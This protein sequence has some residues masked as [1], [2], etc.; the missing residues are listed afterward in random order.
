MEVAPS[1]PDHLNKHPVVF[2]PGLR[3][4]RR[5]SLKL[6][7]KSEQTLTRRLII[8]DVTWE[9]GAHGG[10][11]T[12]LQLV[13]DAEAGTQLQ[14]HQGPAR[15]QQ[16]EVQA[17]GHDAQ[18]Q[19][20]CRTGGGDRRSE[21]RSAADLRQLRLMLMMLNM[22]AVVS[23]YEWI[24]FKTGFYYIMNY[25]SFLQK[26]LKQL[27][28]LAAGAVV[29]FILLCYYKLYLFF[30]SKGAQEFTEV[31]ISNWSDEWPILFE[32]HHTY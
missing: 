27:F 20:S 5:K 29:L 30:I 18:P 26:V 13:H 16:G 9:G 19:D 6:I 3:S 23:Q 32:N 25:V 11:G 31:K 7:L 10:E 24:V 14:D 1:D 21:G 4:E 15:E 8:T 17:L 28:L 12:E 22:L 2:D